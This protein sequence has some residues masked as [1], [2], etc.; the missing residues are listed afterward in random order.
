VKAGLIDFLGFG[1]HADFIM[2]WEPEF[3]Q[4]AVDTCT[5]ESG[6][7]QDCPIFDVVDEA[8]AKECEFKMPLV[9][10]AEKVLE[11]L[12]LLPGDVDITY[13]DGATEEEEE[14]TPSTKPTL[15]YTPGDTPSD[16][17]TPLPGQVFKESSAYVAP[18]PT[19]TSSSTPSVSIAEVESTSTPEPVPEPEPT[20]TSTPVV[21]EPD[22]SYASTQYVTNGNVVSK[23]LWAEETVW[24]TEVVGSTT[25][26]TALGDAPTAPTD[27]ANDV[28]EAL[29][30]RRAAHLHGHGHRHL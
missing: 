4:E 29:R 1:Y 26:V 19:T 25:T 2:G 8:T 3:L 14:P 11:G 15:S 17:A 12:G 22:I 20:T 7:I 10:L 23:I 16:I 27:D 5:N 6:R 24:Q 30:K 18:V 9:L 28:G 21:E 13:G